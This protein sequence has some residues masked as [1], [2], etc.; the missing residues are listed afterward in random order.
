MLKAL[1]GTAAQAGIYGAAQNLSVVPGLIA[2]GF[3]PLLLS[4][5]SRMLRDGGSHSARAMSR[6]AMRMILLMM[7]FAGFTAGAASE[8]VALILG[9][10]FLPA[11]PLLSILIFSALAGLMI[12]VTT[13]VLTAG[14]KPGLTFALTGPLLPLALVGHLLAIPWLGAIGASLVTTSLACLGALATVLAVH[15]MWRVLPPVATLGR[16][17]LITGLAYALAVYWP[18]P[19]FW[20]LIKLPAIGLLIGASFLLLG[21]F[22]KGEVGLPLSFLRLR[23]AAQENAEKI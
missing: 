11:A 19:G 15:H 21:E 20:L 5:L 17:A 13:A 6:N 18:V 8:I 14:G 23:I 10:S 9:T 4:T 1:G 7:P 3:A 22:S 2:T 16:S 12:S